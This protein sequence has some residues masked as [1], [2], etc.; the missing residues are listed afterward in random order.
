MLVRG[1]VIVNDRHLYHSHNHELSDGGWGCANVARLRWNRPASIPLCSRGHAAS[2]DGSGTRRSSSR[3][4][5]FAAWL[6]WLLDGFDV[7][8]YA[9][10]IGALVGEWSLTKAMAGL[11]GSLTLIASG[12]G[13]VLFGYVADRWGRRPALVGS[14]L[15]YSI[16]TFACGL[17]AT[18]WQLA[19]FRF[20]LGL[21]MGGEWTSGAAL[22]AE[23]WPD[24]HRG[25]AMGVMQSA[26][27]VGYALAA[28]V[29]AIVLPRFGWRAVF[30]V[31][32][33]PAFAAIWI[34]R[35]IDESAEWRRSRAV[36]STASSPIR[37]I[38]SK[39]YLV[40]T[41]LLTVLSTTT[42]FAYWGL[43]LWIPAYFSLPH[44]EG[45]L[46]LATGVSTLL[47]VLTQAG[48][49][50]GYLSFGFV[51]DAYGRRRS[52]VTYILTGT[53]LILGF[54]AT[55]NI[56]ILAILAPATTFFA[57]GLFSGFG[58]VTAELY[59]TAIRATATGFTY[60]VGR[61][62]SALSPFVV[63][64][65]AETNGFGMAFALLAIALGLGAVPW[66]WLPETRQRNP[67]TIPA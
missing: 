45:G 57:T 40:P 9:L 21:G 22:V 53:V 41:V 38:F 25:K 29:A 50:L 43:N 2:L 30:F 26:W 7:M 6:G 44:T 18:I 32:I 39:P 56:W 4:T 12:A 65:L 37:A 10:V 59:P 23:T 60:N 51:A 55:R 16:F 64:S 3:R 28:L 42:I 13:G 62:G 54:A 48:T 47:I 46:G 20:L 31:G 49:F 14:L 8:L 67:V 34:Q 58:A 52:F 19:V 1:G 61:I 17:S 24:A 27:S 36:R 11:L 35:S 33:L 5:L 66:I 63:G 15:V